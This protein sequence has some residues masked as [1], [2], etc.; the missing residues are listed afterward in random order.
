MIKKALLAAALAMPA[1]ALAAPA[2]EQQWVAAATAAVAFGQQQ[3]MPIRLRVE[4]G[5]GLPGHTPVGIQS[6]K[7]VCTLVVSAR[8][9]P[10]ADRLSSMIDPDLL[11]LFLQ[12]AAIHEVGHCHRRLSGFPHNERLVAPAT[13]FG[14]ARS[15]FARRVRTEEAF[16]DM[17]A[18]AWVAR[19]HPQHFERMVDQMARVR[20][21][22]LEPK[23]DTLMWLE[24]ARRE[25]A[26]DPG[27]NLFMLAGNRLAHRD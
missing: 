27:G 11:E 26:R 23:H 25:G 8:N 10:T 24:A 13:W 4:Q 9:N 16:A 5:N 3:G 17:T 22:F 14:F 12:S 21:R 6:E 20:M 1:V 18:V 7:G 2:T 15:W 19:Y